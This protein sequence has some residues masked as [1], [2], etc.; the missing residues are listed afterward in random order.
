MK[1]HQF[2]EP[3]LEFGG[4]S[5]IDIRF[6][7]ANYGPF[8]ISQSKR[9]ERINTGIIGTQQTVTELREW[10]ERC[11]G[12]VV[13]EGA[14][15]ATRRDPIFPGFS[16]DSPFKSTVVHEVSLCVAIRPAEFHRL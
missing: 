10:I 1:L 5:H 2:D 15:Q 13:P 11:S 12:E 6:G 7:L 16:K 3:E 14:K 8:D 4:A 9:P